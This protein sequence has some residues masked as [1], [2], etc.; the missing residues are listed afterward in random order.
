MD[1][2]YSRNL[3][4]DSG[5]AI[6]F[7]LTTWRTNSIGGEAI[8]RLKTRRLEL[9]IFTVIEYLLPFVIRK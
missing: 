4:C 8:A 9:E 3:R 5:M 2:I 6:Y 7:E 1:A